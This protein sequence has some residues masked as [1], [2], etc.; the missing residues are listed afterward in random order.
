M[1]LTSEWD[2][3]INTPHTMQDEYE[4]ARDLGA[5]F[6]LTTDDQGYMIPVEEGEV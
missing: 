3:N 4:L 5:A 2:G 1:L 6:G